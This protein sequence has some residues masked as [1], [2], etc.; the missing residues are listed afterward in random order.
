MLCEG[1][2]VKKEKNIMEVLVKRSSA[3]GE[4]CGHCNAC[5]GLEQIVKVEDVDGIFVGDTVQLELKSKNVLN[6]AFLVYILP[7]ILLI[8]GYIIAGFFFE[9]D[10]ICASAGFIFMIIGFFALH[11]YDAKKG[12][13]YS[14]KAVLLTQDTQNEPQ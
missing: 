14:P 1:L 10:V 9:S 6:A 2:V 3:C 12:E 8:L 13:K 11:F 7:L 4:N 5:S